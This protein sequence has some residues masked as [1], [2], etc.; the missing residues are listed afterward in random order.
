M[1]ALLYHSKQILQLPHQ[2]MNIQLKHTAGSSLKKTQMG[3]AFALTSF[4]STTLTAVAQI[5]EQGKPVIRMHSGGTAVA[6]STPKLPL[7]PITR[8]RV[9]FS[10]MA[11]KSDGC[12][13]A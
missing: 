9:M 7:L 4:S 11:E 10:A 1:C 13:T 6:A 5:G 3:V 12:L 2:L 8:Y